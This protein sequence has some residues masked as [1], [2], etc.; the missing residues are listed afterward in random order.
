MKESPNCNNAGRE[1][2]EKQKRLK[3]NSYQFKKH[4]QRKMYA[5]TK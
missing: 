5:Q 1:K 2:M 4:V 3:N